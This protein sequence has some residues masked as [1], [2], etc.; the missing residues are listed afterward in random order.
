M[1]YAAD[2][3]ALSGGDD[4][5]RN[6]GRFVSLTA[7]TV[8]DEG[9]DVQHCEAG[10]MRQSVRQYLA[11]M[12]ANGKTNVSRSEFDTLKAILTNCVRRGRI[13]SKP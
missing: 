2:D 10:V 5:A 7:A 1:K 12:V 6:V 11:R 3:L 13:E 4:F 9:W 8:M